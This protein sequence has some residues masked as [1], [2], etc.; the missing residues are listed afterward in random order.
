MANS[1]DLLHQRTF[2]S[3]EDTL[4]LISTFF[5]TWKTVLSWTPVIILAIR[6][7]SNHEQRLSKPSVVA[8]STVWLHLNTFSQMED[9]LPL[10]HRQKDSST[11]GKTVLPWRQVNILA[12]CKGL[13]H[14]FTLSELVAV[15]NSTDLLYLRTF[16]SVEDTLPLTSRFFNTW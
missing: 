7:G 13:N 16:P 10:Y 5:N 12:I 8:Y 6:T 3:V 9:A 11:P 2:P 14:E 15:A 4:P 1:T